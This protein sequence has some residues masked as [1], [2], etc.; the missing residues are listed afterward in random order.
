MKFIFSFFVVFICQN[1]LAQFSYLQIK[2]AGDRECSIIDSIGYSKR[3]ANTKSVVEQANLF[4]DKLLKNGYLT[5]KHEGVITVNDSTFLFN[6]TLGVR[7][8]FIHIHIGKDFELLNLKSDLLKIPIAETESFMNTALRFLEKK[9]Y[10]LARLQL[11]DF[12]TDS[13]E[14]FANLSL[15]AEKIRTL[16][17]IVINGYD[18]FPA[19]H[20]KQIKRLYRNKVFNQENLKKV[21]NDFGKF[22]FVSQ[23]KYPEI[24]FTKDSTKVYVYLEKAKP[25]TF[26]GYIG[27]T[28]NEQK[29]LIVNGY[30]DLQ[31]ENIMNGGEKISLYWKS[32]GRNQKTFNGAIEIPYVFKSP[33][34]IKA[35]LNIFKQDSLFQNTQTAIDLGYYFN[36]NTKAFL[37]Y[38]SAE[39]SD[40]QNT[41]SA[42]LRDFKNAFITTHLDFSVYNPDDYLFPDKTK[43]Y[44]K[45]GIGKRDLE[46]MSNSQFFS[47]L[48][49]SH[50]FYLNKKNIVNIR[51]LNYYL[52][53]DSYVINELQRFGG[54]NSIRGFSENSL[55]G[56][57]LSLVLTEYRYIAN[58]NIYIHSIIDYGYYQ[59]KSSNISKTLVG[60][61]FGLGLL[62]KNGLFN[63]IYANGSTK[64]QAIKLP[65]SIVHVSFKAKF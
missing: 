31:L 37:G 39:S 32:D 50:N 2:G 1:A 55:Q 14:L 13:N 21:Y 20:K 15:G 7:N 41:N 16:D 61:G 53:S 10:S 24:L 45:I 27:F 35:Q 62:T 54:I 19:G 63:L 4:A 8:K 34:G 3:H 59:D 58:S 46:I 25:N 26:D 12:K 6:Y 57:A 18:K 23:P 64:E 51:S 30:L 11:T 52:N 28:N 40:I 60:L 48:N 49:L 43:I 17:D 22:R 36:Y 5:A 33:L 56:N 29:K 9:G 47:T 42:T 38:Q 44:F 65:N